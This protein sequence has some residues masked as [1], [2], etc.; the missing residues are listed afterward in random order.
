L[1]LPLGSAATHCRVV[2][3][4]GTMSESGVGGRMRPSVDVGGI[5]KPETVRVWLFGGFR[6][7]VGPRTVDHRAWR[8]RKAATL[9]KLLALAPG[10]R[11]HREQAIDVLWPDSGGGAASNSLR[12]VLH[13]ARRALAPDTSEG[14][15]Y[16]R[17][18][19]ESIA[20]CPDGDLWIDVESFEEAAS[21]AR[22]DDEP[23]AYRAAIDLYAGPLL[24]EDRYER[25]SE[26]HRRELHE[27]YVS[28]H[29]GLALGLE[30]YGHYGPAIEALLKVVAEDATR[31]DV[32][33]ELMRLYALSGSRVQALR[34]YE[35]LAGTVS[36]ELGIEP[37]APARA[38]KEEI[39]SGR[40]PPDSAH[41]LDHSSKEKAD[42]HPFGLSVP[43]TSFVGRG[44][45]LTK[46]KRALGMTRLLTLTGTG[47]S[48]KTRLALE[49][50][51]ELAGAYPDG[52][53]FV[54]LAGI[55]E[56]ELLPQVV[57][58]A[59]G[60]GEQPGRSRAQACADVL[61]DKRALLVAD[62][63]EHVVEATARLLDFLL[64]SCSHLR[65]LATS[66]EPLGVRDETLFSVPPLPV[67]ADVPADVDE[68][69]RKDSV[70]L[71]VA[72]ARQRLPDFALTRD[73][74][75]AVATVCRRLEGIPLAIELAS[76][77]MGILAVDQVAERLEDSLGLLSSGP[78]TAPPRHRTMR[79]T[80]EWSHRLLSEGEMALFEQLSVFAG[81]FALEA[82]EAVCAD[83]IAEEGEVLDLL[84]GLADKSL[85]VV[86]TSKQGRVRYRM[87]E[88]IRQ[89]GRERLNE[90]GESGLVA[91][92][93]AAYFLELA[94][95]A[96]P[97]L[98]GP[99]QVVWLER[100]EEENDNLRATMAWLLEEN[101]IE[102]AVRLAWALWIFW[103]IRGHQGEGRR[104]IE[105]ALSK[106]ADL[107][108][109]ARARALSV[110]FSTYYGLG[111]T[112]RLG[113]IAEEA[114]SLFRQVG[115][116][117]GL[118]YSL[119]FLAGVRLQQG[120]AERALA[121]FE[122]AD[123]LAR[124]AGDVWGLSGGLAHQGAIHLG[125][126]NYEQAARC[127]A[128]GLKLSREIGNKLAEASA[129]YGLAMAEQG[130]G[131]HERA[132]ELYAE[133]LI[134]SA[135][136]GDRANTAYCLDGLA[137]VAAARGET[138]R[139]AR[140]FGAA[141]AS[142]KA[143]GMTL[144]P[145]A[146]G[147]FLREQAVEE[148]RSRMGAGA[149]SATWTEGSTLDP[150]E[151]V[152]YALSSE[153]PVPSAGYAVRDEGLT[154]GQSNPT[155]REK[156]VALLVTRGL[157]NHQVATELHISEHTVATHVGRILKKLGLRSRTELAAWMTRQERRL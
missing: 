118:A 57:A 78:R 154:G 3:F 122:E 102:A 16:L 80:I 66:R 71:F 23:A 87:L 143:A 31:E 113:K 140:L 73:N 141:A 43:R 107:T 121:L 64:S 74:A 156:E 30:R 104:W 109:H 50:A 53:W 62:N 112:E 67:P 81:G 37:S 8:L 47:G 136:S 41:S 52:I 108:A 148:V 59:L 116:G 35:V 144:Y 128:D 132:A 123:G 17:F 26:Q 25:W 115:D 85:V 40:F 12:Q 11:M 88:P 84:T 92:R 98:K 56:A 15:R 46:I 77:R 13:A 86:D 82:A 135:E 58:A 45:E 130:R 90:T 4:R 138:E 22:R 137:Q 91:R 97:Q 129:L 54:E 103:L 72:R 6:V 19:E 68:V 65:V 101:E 38:L 152:E 83:R 147:Q 34:R 70:R 29:L 51:T 32:H 155:R 33:F 124:E 111:S 120:S 69:A 24:P 117:L 157:T 139:A 131:N 21:T 60:V 145:Y 105:E 96:E 146:E 75:G 76:A 114:A 49:V 149:F 63:C 36:R 133:G 126:G 7:S 106:G 127:L 151:A 18:E 28:L 89:Y 10:H 93:H 110:Q 9:V 5:T 125:R 95:L 27:T 134:S 55:S 150:P 44:H 20:L 48:G 142:L 94:E 42:P 99:G 100:L 153:G 2:P 119:G 1:L 79:A 14:F 61:L 39:A